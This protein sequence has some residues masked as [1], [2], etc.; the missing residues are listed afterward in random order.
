MIVTT[1]WNRSI[2]ADPTTVSADGQATTTITVLQHACPSLA[3]G[4]LIG[5]VSVSGTDNKLSLQQGLV[6]F[7]GGS[8]STPLVTTL[9]SDV[10]ETKQVVVTLAPETQPNLIVGQV[11]VPVTFV[12]QSPSPATSQL[13]FGLANGVA[14]GV[15][16][17][18]VTVILDDDQGNPVKNFPVKL[19][20]SNG[21]LLDPPFGSTDSEGNFVSQLTSSNPGTV[22]VSMQ[23]APLL[24]KPIDFIAA[25]SNWVEANTNASPAQLQSIFGTGG[26]D[27]WAV[28][29]AKTVLHFDGASWQSES[30]G[31]APTTKTYFG[32]WAADTAH[33]WAVGTG[34]ISTF[35]D[36]TWQESVVAPTYFGV[37]GLDASHVWI[38]GASGSILFWDGANLFEQNSPIL[39][40][41]NVNAISIGGA[42]PSDVWVGTRDSS[43]VGS[44][45]FWDGEGW[46]TQFSGGQFTGVRGIVALSPSDVWA[47]GDNG[48]TLHF[49]GSAW[50]PFS[51]GTAQNLNAVWGTDTDHV[52]AVGND[53][54]ILFWNGFSWVD[55][56]PAFAGADLLGVWGI[57]SAHV[58][59]VGALG[60]DLAQLSCSSGT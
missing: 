3:Y 8:E 33:A 41:V 36:G 18:K 12:G 29:Q 5:T 6:T 23:L 26:S 10:G 56:S 60:A 17:V 30:T 27:I 48:M 37:W 24:S 31:S 13:V 44:I 28:G 21:A 53:S 11:S 49:D 35:V 47:V 40:D 34:L 42:D 52:W 15:S 45:L 54:T 57:D 7:G 20:A 1:C 50:G 22:T 14:D 46:T 25:C 4:Q 19:G 51:S 43:N 38:V 59:A 9:S 32:V 2:S 16:P 39:N 55:Q 58:A